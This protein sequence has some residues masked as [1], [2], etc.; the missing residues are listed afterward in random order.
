MKYFVAYLLSG[1]AKSYHER[2]TRQIFEKYKTA[3]F[4]EKVPPHVT[5]KAPFEATDEGIL[6]V[7]RV[8]RAFARTA[9]APSFVLEGFGH[10]GFR[11][12]YLNGEGKEATVFV[13]RC[14]KLLRENIPWMSQSP[15]EGNKLHAS[16]ARFLSRRKFERIWRA[17]KGACPSVEVT[18]DNVAIL[19]QTDGVWKVHALIPVRTDTFTRSRETPVSDTMVAV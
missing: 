1:S 7:E 19:K 18:L 12:V 4:F 11:T 6:D 8:L 15:L 9:E 2:L 14:I 16:V 10:F 13:R 3:R 17:L 5:I